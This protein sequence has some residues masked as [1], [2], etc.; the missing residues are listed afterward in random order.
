MN[1]AMV[2]F[3][4]LAA[5]DETGGVNYSPCSTVDGVCLVQ[6]AGLAERAPCTQVGQFCDAT[7]VATPNT[8]CVGSPPAAPPGPATVTV[9]G[10]V[11]ALGS[12]PDTSGFSLAFYD[13]A[14]LAAGQPLVAVAPIATQPSVILDRHERPGAVT[15][16]ACDIDPLVGCSVPA[17]GCNC[18]DGLL[19]TNPDGS[20]VPRPDE[21]QYCRQLASG[22]TCA[23]R[24][25]WEALY[26]VA[27]LPTNKQLAV[28]VTGTGG[29]PTVWA[30]VVNWNVFLSTGAPACASAGDQNCLDLSNPAAPVYHLDLDVFSSV[31][32]ANLPKEAG[33]AGG[34][35]P[36]QGAL[37]GEVRDCDDV[38]VEN[39]VVG[40]TPQA[41][42]ESYFND[43]PVALRPSSLKLSTDRFGLYTAFGLHP[44]SVTVVA[45]GTL[46]DG[47]PLS[48]LG[49]FAP[50]VY[51]NTISLVHINRGHPSP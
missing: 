12:G 7:G 15:Q 9:V 38:R 26:S 19:I 37:Y 6:P 10:F 5:C 8:S 33:L 47:A 51:A 48:S 25:R 11:H 49:S 18:A 21:G 42:L 46:V 36:G 24:E 22:N 30:S 31:D 16:R 20:V 32:Y 29:D 35:P 40:T 50:V 1:R 27:N 4:L 3:A 43:N 45:A 39:A 17:T 23:Q 13:A 41:A 34:V 14:P 2:L 44:G 28:H